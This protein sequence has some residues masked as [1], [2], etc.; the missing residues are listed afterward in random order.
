MQK[1]TIQARMEEIK[2]IMKKGEDL[3]CWENLTRKLVDFQSLQNKIWKLGLSSTQGARPLM[4]AG[5][6]KTSG[7]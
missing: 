1:N 4:R 6:K 3:T 5:G 2:N 7:F